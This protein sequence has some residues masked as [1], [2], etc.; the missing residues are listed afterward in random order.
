MNYVCLSALSFFLFP[1]FKKSIKYKCSITWKIWSLTCWLFKSIGLQKY[2]SC[3]NLYTLS[4]WNFNVHFLVNCNLNF[5]FLGKGEKLMFLSF[6]WVSLV[7][8]DVDS[9]LVAAFMILVRKA[10]FLSF[11][12][13]LFTWSHEKGV[14]K[15]SVL[16]ASFFFFLKHAFNFLLL[17]VA[18]VSPFFF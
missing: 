3:L 11:M 6:S 12:F 15:H 13:S 9:V 5:Y 10:F 14:F 8:G 16:R 4:V 1:L 17:G 18:F 2:L 7:G